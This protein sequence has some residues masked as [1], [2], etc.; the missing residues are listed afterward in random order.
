MT[1]RIP[2]AGINLFQLIYVLIREYKEKTGEEPLNLS[3][4]NPD[5]VPPEP[6]RALKAKYAKDPGYAYH[7]YA[8]DNNL[9]RFAEGMVSLHGGIDVEKFHHLRALP[10]AG[11]KTASALVPLACGLH[12]P[13]GGRRAAFRVASNLPAY[14]VIG[15]WSSSYLAAKRTVWP[16]ATSDNMRLNVS[17]LKEALKR[18]GTDR[19]DLIF[20]IRP[21]NPAAV[22]ASESDWKELIEFCLA[23]G[24]RLVNDAAYAGLTAGHAHVP[25][26]QVAKDYPE[27]EWLELYSVSKSYNDP[28]A[29]L[30]ALVGSKEF[31]ED[32]VL[33]KGN[34]DSG[35]VPGV[36]AAYGEFFSDRAAAAKALGEIRNLYERRVAYLVPQLEKAGLRPA[37]ATAAGFFTLWKVPKS[38][39]GREL[40]VENRHEA[41]NRAVISETG[42]VGVHFSGFGED[43]TPEPLIRY[44]VCADVLDPKFQARLEERLARLKPVY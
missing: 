17:R 22:G 10:I 41:F 25:L 3:L 44:A 1:R 38:V 33:V 2:A 21:G 26:A 35:P 9:H 13:D 12:L 27:L 40:P 6:I 42:I 23:K 8:E 7:T 15:T 24:I 30:G 31:V 18:D 43:G 34:T 20:T 36:M 29:R 11:I 5:G 32:F 39:L 16:L 4:G 14:D 28:G 19:A 37:C